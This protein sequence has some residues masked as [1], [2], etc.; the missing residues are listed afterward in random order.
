MFIHSSHIYVY[1]Y[2]SGILVYEYTMFIEYTMYD[3][4]MHLP[5]KRRCLPSFKSALGFQTMRNASTVSV[6]QPCLDSHQ[7]RT[8]VQIVP[9]YCLVV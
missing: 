4:H 3:L 1:V 2:T 9:K 5:I 6:G 7:G 8:E